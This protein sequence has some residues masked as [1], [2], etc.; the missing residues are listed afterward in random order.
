LTGQ[1][2]T[3][4]RA[5]SLRGKSHGE[6]ILVNLVSEALLTISTCS[7]SKTSL[8]RKTISK[9]KAST[10]SRKPKSQVAK[11][12]QNAN[13][14]HDKKCC[15]RKTPPP[16]KSEKSSSGKFDSG[17]NH[18]QF[19]FGA[20]GPTAENS[21]DGKKAKDG[22]KDSDEA[23]NPKSQRAKDG[24]DDAKKSQEN[25]RYG[26]KNPKRYTSTKH[27]P[28]TIGIF[29]SMSVIA[30]DGPTELLGMFPDPRGL[31][32]DGK[33]G[34]SESSGAIGLLDL[35]LDSDGLTLPPNQYSNKYNQT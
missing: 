6:I 29:S 9:H 17:R 3:E 2:L 7:S 26:E 1:Y 12:G 13:K 16:K 19:C 35:G 18:R 32:F 10:M 14:G 24:Q 15:F 25:N 30:C 5:A 28:Q 31:N 11:D 33:D 20:A 8:K 21:Q 22:G 27:R 23:K 4:N 34:T